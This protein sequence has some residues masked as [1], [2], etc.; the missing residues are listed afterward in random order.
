MKACSTVF[1]MVLFFV[2]WN[3]FV[4]RCQSGV[5]DV[6]EWDV[7][8]SVFKDFFNFCIPPGSGLNDGQWH[9]IRL[10][11]KEN[12]AMLMIDGEEASAVRSTSPLTINTGG[13]YHLGGEVRPNTITAYLTK[14][15]M[16]PC[17]QLHPS[18][19]VPSIREDR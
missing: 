4:P 13:T 12:Y 5:L 3:F 9:A 2:I 18:I 15:N 7:I 8:S 16:A 19:T 17:L 6:L 11:A 10:V 1:L 14:H